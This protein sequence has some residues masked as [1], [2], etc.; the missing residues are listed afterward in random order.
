MRVAKI[1][2]GVSKIA[3]RVYINWKTENMEFF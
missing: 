1:D 3:F 2:K